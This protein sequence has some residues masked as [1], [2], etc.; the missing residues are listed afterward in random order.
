MGEVQAERRVFLYPR[1]PFQGAEKIRDVV[2][3]RTLYFDRI[4]ERFVPEREQFVMLGVGYDTR[5][6]GKL[7]RDGLAFFE[8]D[9]AETQRLKVASLGQASTRTM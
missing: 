3:A 8:L 2:V 5:A 6:Y 7:K 4:I 1:V 9:Q